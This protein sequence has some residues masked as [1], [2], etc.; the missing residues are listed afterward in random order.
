MTAPSS[1]SEE[2]VT[3]ECD[4]SSRR[5]AAGSSQTDSRFSRLLA[6]T[7]PTWLTMTYSAP[8]TNPP[9]SSSTSSAS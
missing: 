2:V 7:L 9:P 1:L 4:C 6:A 8:P 3:S 5:R